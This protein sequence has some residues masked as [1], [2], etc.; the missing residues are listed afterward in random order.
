MGLRLC[1][2]AHWPPSHACQWPHSCDNF[3]HATSVRTLRDDGFNA[4]SGLGQLPL[5]CRIDSLGGDERDSETGK[6]CRD[7]MEEFAHSQA[8]LAC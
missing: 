4:V 8:T 7:R 5:A 1:G 2:F 3:L 6:L